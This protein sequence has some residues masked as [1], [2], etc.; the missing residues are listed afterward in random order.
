M[1]TVLRAGDS[2]GWA[3]P[4]EGGQSCYSIY[5]LGDGHNH[6]QAYCPCRFLILFNPS[7]TS[8]TVEIASLK[9]YAVG[10]GQ[11]PTPMLVDVHLSCW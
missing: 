11:E 9:I 6:N 2:K 10:S 8:V 3:C 4:V 7:L 5:V 1:L